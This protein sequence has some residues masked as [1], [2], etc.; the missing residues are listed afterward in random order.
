MVVTYKDTFE[1]THVEVLKTHLP[2][3]IVD[4]YVESTDAYTKMTTDKVGG[5]G[6]VL[7]VSPPKTFEP[8][9]IW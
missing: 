8:T 5:R 6:K 9:N 7:D 4:L 2:T 1:Q 3:F